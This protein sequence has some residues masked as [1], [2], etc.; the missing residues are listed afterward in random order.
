MAAAGFQGQV[1]GQGPAVEA[2]EGQPQPATLA[3]PRRPPAGRRWRLPGRRRWR[4][5][6]GPFQPAASTAKASSRRR[7]EAVARQV[8]LA[9]D[10]A[11]G[12]QAAGAA[13]QLAAAM[14]RQ[15]GQV[16]LPG[17]PA[18]SRRGTPGECGGTGGSRPRP[19]R[20]RR[21]LRRWAPRPGTKSTV[22]RGRPAA[23]RASA[24][25]RRAASSSATA[26][27]QGVCQFAGVY[28][29]CR[30]STMGRIPASRGPHQTVR[31]SRRTPAASAQGSSQPGRAKGAAPVRSARLVPGGDDG[32]RRPRR[33]RRWGPGSRCPSRLPSAGASGRP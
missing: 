10:L 8:D 1:E 11:G 30:R 22:T 13:A 21:R 24:R 19:A 18:R 4:C 3:P 15:R 25:A 29:R 27:S 28:A 23:A 5:P 31:A 14:G 26:S 12:F 9:G 16:V 20:R 33:G 17:A 6:R 7:G 32:C 2:E